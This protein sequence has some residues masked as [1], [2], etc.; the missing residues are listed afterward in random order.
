MWNYRHNG[1]LGTG[2]KT[3]AKLTDSIV[4]IANQKLKV[5]GFKIWDA[6]KPQKYTCSYTLIKNGKFLYV[7]YVRF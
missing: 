6:I 1:S 3:S 4:F 7:S 2:W 5:F